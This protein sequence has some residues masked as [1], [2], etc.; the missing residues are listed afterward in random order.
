MRIGLE[1]IFN[2]YAPLQLKTAT[3][4]PFDGTEISLRRNCNKVY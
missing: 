3:K 1:G 2:Y 4:T